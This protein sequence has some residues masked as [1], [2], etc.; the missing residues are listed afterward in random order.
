MK[1]NIAII[2]AGLGGISTAARLAKLNYNV[3]VYEKNNLPG[4][5]C[6]NIYID[7]ARFDQGPTMLIMKEYIEELFDFLDKPLN[8][9]LNKCNDNCH[10]YFD[11]N[12]VFKMTT[13]KKKM[14]REM[15][16]IEK[17]SYVEYKKFL[18]QSEK[19]YS[20]SKKIL[21]NTFNR[22]YTFINKKNIKDAIKSNIHI[23]HYDFVSKYFKTN[24]LRMALTFQNM[25]VGMSP[26]DA[27]AT[28]TLLQYSEC[29]KG[30]YYPVGGIWKLVERIFE[31]T[32]EMGVKYHFNSEI[33]EILH[34]YNKVEGIKINNNEIKKYDIIILNT[35]IEHGYN[36]LKIDKK[37]NQLKRSCSVICFYWIINK[38]LDLNVNNIFLP[39]KYK[40]SFDSIFICN[41]IPDKPSFYIHIPNKIDP[42]ADKYGIMVLVPTGINTN[43]SYCKKYI[44]KRLKKSGIDFLIL[45]EKIISPNEWE[46]KYNLKDGSVLGFIHSIF[47][48]GYFRPSNICKEIQNTYFVGACTQPGAGIPLVIRSSK[49]VVDEIEKIH[50]Q[51]HFNKNNN[52]F[53]FINNFISFI[54]NL[55]FYRL[56][57]FRYIKKKINL[58]NNISNI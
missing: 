1:E 46:N 42:T 45:K 10:V 56:N 12:S 36:L 24:K 6:Q 23:S 13:C 3:T 41:K 26:F 8:I 34:K 17:G 11:D 20:F 7:N 35:E 51:N 22:W 49:F 40:E 30:I 28:F 33:T 14:E 44:L 16:K 5:V 15:E 31:I 21:K 57:L 54:N 2:G 43:I 48:I 38:E 53:F 55:Y 29:T 25:Y 47:Q 19:H 27:P 52:I 39:K 50:K 37:F 9:K 32:K 58:N 18:S 4:G